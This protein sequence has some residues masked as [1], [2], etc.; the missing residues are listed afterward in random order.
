M[1]GFQF[2]EEIQIG[3]EPRNPYEKKMRMLTMQLWN[4]N[5]E[6]RVSHLLLVPAVPFL[7]ILPRRES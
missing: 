2:A 1:T 6:M 7:Y 4:V 3:R 5:P